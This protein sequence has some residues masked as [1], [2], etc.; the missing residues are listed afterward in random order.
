MVVVPSGGAA[1][2][3]AQPAPPEAIAAVPA[4]PGTRLFFTWGAGTQIQL[5]E[6]QGQGAATSQGASASTVAW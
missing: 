2:A 4:A 6:L 3:V 1:D 5:C